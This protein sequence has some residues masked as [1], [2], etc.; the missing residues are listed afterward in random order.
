MSTEKKN[1]RACAHSYMEPDGPLVCGAV[2][3]PWGLTIRQDLVNC[4]N[5]RLFEQHPLRN[6]D[7]SLKK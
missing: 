7:G 3:E 2:N 6:P 4:G 5:G 1:C